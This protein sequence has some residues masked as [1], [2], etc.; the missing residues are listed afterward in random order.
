[1]LLPSL[2]QRSDVLVGMATPMVCRRGC[3]RPRGAAGPARVAARRAGVRA[4]A[5]TAATARILRT[6]GSPSVVAAGGRRSVWSLDGSV[7]RSRGPAAGQSEPLRESVVGAGS[8][9]APGGSRRVVVPSSMSA[10]SVPSISARSPRCSVVSAVDM[11]RVVRAAGGQPALGRRARSRAPGFQTARATGSFGS[12]CGGATTLDLVA[13]RTG[14]GRRGRTCPSMHRLARGGV[15]DQAHRVLA[16]ADA[17]RVDLDA[18]PA[19]PL[20]VGQTSSMWAPRI[21]SLPGTRW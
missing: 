4:R 10:S 2:I 8:S 11:H 7:C 17:E 9:A 18:G 13:R 21:S 12:A 3:P 20:R 19:R 5:A 6:G 1:M 16:A 14:S 15:E